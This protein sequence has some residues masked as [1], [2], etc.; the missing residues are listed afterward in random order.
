MHRLHVTSDKP[1]LV[2]QTYLA[3]KF[4]GPTNKITKFFRLTSFPMTA[5]GGKFSRKSSCVTQPRICFSERLLNANQN[6]MSM[7]L[8]ASNA[9]NIKECHRQVVAVQENVAISSRRKLGKALFGVRSTIFLALLIFR[10]Y[11]CF[12]DVEIHQKQRSQTI[13]NDFA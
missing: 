7:N 6:N 3:E 11:F 13:T 8:G 10:K 1:S 2:C 9:T 12:L 5:I 4:A